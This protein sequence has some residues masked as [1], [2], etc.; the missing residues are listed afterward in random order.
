[1][2]EALHAQERR[3]VSQIEKYRLN[4]CLG[5][6]SA[7]PES[8]MRDRDCGSRQQSSRDESQYRDKI[9]MLATRFVSKRRPRMQQLPGNSIGGPVSPE[10]FPP[11]T[12]RV[13][14][15]C[16]EDGVRWMMA[17][18]RCNTGFHE[19]LSAGWVGVP[20]GSGGTGGHPQFMCCNRRR[21]PTPVCTPGGSISIRD[22]CLPLSKHGAFWKSCESDVPTS[23][24]IQ[25]RMRPA[26]S[27]ATAEEQLR[28]HDGSIWFPCPV[29]LA[30]R[31]GF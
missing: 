5:R 1:M 24:S 3:A 2:V 14:W 28:G 29:G 11:F 16:S 18:S 9:A 23:N 17:R 4:G 22:G 6:T 20:G 8:E 19:V 30:I 26:H 12:A 10:P 13:R 27:V 25:P 21:S 31:R 7:G 15:Q